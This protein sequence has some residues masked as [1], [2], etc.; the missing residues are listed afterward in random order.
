[1]TSRHVIYN[2]DGQNSYPVGAT[3]YNMENT[4][5][6]CSDARLYEGYLFEQL[7]ALSMAN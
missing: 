4:G 7:M 2:A 3:R 1:M 5:I 6:S